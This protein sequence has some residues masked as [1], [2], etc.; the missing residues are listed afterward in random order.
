MSLWDIIFIIAQRYESRG[1]NVITFV[2]VCL[3]AKYQNESLDAYL[4]LVNFWS[5]IKTRWLPQLIKINN[6]KSDL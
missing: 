2:C 3:L 4:H 1:N 6:H 5:Q